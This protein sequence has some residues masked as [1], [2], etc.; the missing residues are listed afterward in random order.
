MKI[1]GVRVDFG[2]RMA[3]VLDIVERKFIKGGGAGDTHY[4]STTNPEFIVDSQTNKDFKKIINGSDLSIPDGIGV[5]FA[6]HYINRVG[7]FP[8]GIFYPLRCFVAG[9]RVGVRKNLSEERLS[10]AELVEKICELSHNKGYSIFFLGGR[11]RDFS[12]EFSGDCGD[13]LATEAADKMRSKYPNVNIIGSTSQFSK[14]EEDDE[15]T[16]TYIA[17]CMKEAG[18]KNLDF[19]FVAYN[20]YW[21]EKWIARNAKELPARVSVGVGGTFDQFVGFEKSCPK[22]LGNFNLGWLYRLVTQ[23]F[24]F[25]R[26]LKAFPLFPLKIFAQSLL[27]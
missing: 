26:I 20:H 24:R 15:K 19:L 23:P 27:E 5:V 13:D 25:K 12:G 3:D 18:V 11:R 4:I 21:Q 8:R 2:L 17:Q 6:R 10:G 7:K 9:L 14:D 22:V 16:T 1:L